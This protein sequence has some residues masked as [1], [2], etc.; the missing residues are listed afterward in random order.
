MDAETLVDVEYVEV[1]GNGADVPGVVLLPGGSPE[2]LTPE[3]LDGAKEVTCVEDVEYDKVEEGSADTP[4]VVVTGK[5]LPLVE[6]P[7]ALVAKLLNED[8]ETEGSGGVLLLVEFPL[9]LIPCATSGPAA[10]PLGAA[11]LF[12]S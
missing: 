6:F 11:V 3:L 2:A 4:D 12:F 1:G 9:L 5:V 10:P 8:E 7:V